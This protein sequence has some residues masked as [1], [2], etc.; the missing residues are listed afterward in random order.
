MRRHG[1]TAKRR[2]FWQAAENDS[3]ERCCDPSCAAP[4]RRRAA[5]SW[6]AAGRPSAMALVVGLTGGICTGK[7]TVARMLAE[8]GATIIDSDAIAHEI[9]APGQATYAHIVRAFGTGILDETGRIDRRRLGASVFADPG[10]RAVL[11]AI[12][13]PA[14]MAESDRRVRAALAGGARLVVVDAALLVEVGRQRMFARLVVVAA[15]EA[16][17]VRRLRARNGLGE[18]EARQ[19]LAAQMPLGEKRR[20]AHH[21]IENSG[22]LADTAAQVRRLH[23]ELMALAAAGGPDGAYPAVAGG[24][25]GGGVGTGREGDGPPGGAPGGRPPRKDA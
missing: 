16:E 24:D 7:S 10:R 9:Q 19:R 20:H 8:L 15:T 1:D 4:P 22:D 11:E 12:M 25:A 23:A 6:P 14:I 17:Q 18:A 21:V 3:A 2:G 13:H 5:A